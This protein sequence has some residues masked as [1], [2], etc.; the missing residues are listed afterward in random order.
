MSKPSGNQ[1]VTNKPDQDTI[2]RNRQIFNRAEGISH[3]PYS[4]YAGPDVAGPNGYQNDAMR[5]VQGMP[6]MYQNLANQG[7]VQQYQAQQ[8]GQNLMGMINGPEAYR[9]AGD[10]GAAALGGNQNAINKMMNPY[11]QGVIDQVKG[12]YGDLNAQ[13]QMGINDQFTKAGAFG[14]SRQGVASGVASSE[15][16][17]GLGQ[18]IAGLQQSGFNDAMGRAGQAANLGLGAGQLGQGY[19]QLGAQYQGLAQN[20][21]GMQGQMAGAQQG[22][23]GQQFGMGDLYRQLQQQQYGQDRQDFNEK[24]DWDIRNFNILQSGGTGLPAGSTQST[25]LY[26]NPLGAAAGGAAT[27]GAIGGP[28]GAGIGGGIGLISSLF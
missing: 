10:T 23:Y 8:N 25:P 11:Q 12:Q 5:G 9:N 28:I 14:G 19:G 20:A 1:V 6:G 24:R 16:A 2:D 7:A 13:A 26:S 15:I 3:D 18:Q 4:G 27:G 17:K 22:A 21:L